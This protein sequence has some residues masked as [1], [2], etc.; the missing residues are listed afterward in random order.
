MQLKA[1]FVK[2]LILWKRNYLL[3]ICEFA[4]PLMLTGLLMYLN[5]LMTVAEVKIG[6]IDPIFLPTNRLSL[7]NPISAESPIFKNCFSS[8]AASKPIVIIPQNDITK[9]IQTLFDKLGYET[10]YSQ[11]RDS[12]ARAA[13]WSN[14]PQASD[15]IDPCAMI[16]FEKQ[17]PDQFEYTL[18]FDTTAEWPLADHWDTNQPRPRTASV[19]DDAMALR[20]TFSDGIFLLK[21]YIDSLIFEVKFG[22]MLS[23]GT[24]RFKTDSYSKSGISTLLLNVLNLVLI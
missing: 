5:S 23:V 7:K 20:K 16:E 1:L 18:R 2:E 11:S 9:H 12:A 21:N 3:S 6:S 24:N 14:D 22:I 15:L 10:V 13:G 17:G 19:T 4:L 8:D